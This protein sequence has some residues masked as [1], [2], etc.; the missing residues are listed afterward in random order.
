[1]QFFGLCPALF[2]RALVSATPTK[3]NKDDD[4][5]QHSPESIDLELLKPR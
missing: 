1:M 3:K 4:Y 2:R 5:E